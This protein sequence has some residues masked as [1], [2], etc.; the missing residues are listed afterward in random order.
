MWAVTED[1][2]K[3]LLKFAAEDAAGVEYRRDLSEKLGAAFRDAGQ[4][5]W[6]TGVI[7][8][9]D[10]AAGESPFEFGDDATVGLAIVAQVAGELISGA[11]LLLD[12]DNLYAAAALLRQMVEVEYL[13]WAFAEDQ[14]EARA[15]LRSSAGDRQKFWKPGHLRKRSNGR[16]RS[17]DHGMHC[18]QGG[19]PTPDAM[20]L[21]PDHS[22]RA[23]AGWWWYDLAS[24]GVSAWRYLE[25]ACD[26]FDWAARIGE[27]P[28]IEPLAGLITGWDQ[29]DPLPQANATVTAFLR[30]EQDS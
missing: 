8:G 29:G 11:V 5:L 25:V 26:K 1:E 6:L 24:H 12:H 21:L 27:L 9:P 18:N 16:F 30:S 7:I 13:A 22:A 20:R 10:R 19:H 4:A 28:S 23:H 15:W 2:L 14:E 3:N 17:T